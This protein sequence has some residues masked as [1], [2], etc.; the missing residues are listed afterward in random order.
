MRYSH[1]RSVTENVTHPCTQRVTHLKLHTDRSLCVQDPSGPHSVYLFIQLFILS[2]NMLC[3]KFVS[4]NNLHNKLVSF[5]ILCNQV[6]K[7]VFLS[8][9]SSYSKLIKLKGGMVELQAIVSDNL[10]L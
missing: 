1:S 8:S 7:L 6:S 4:F 5:N 10:D 3:N 2:F 9:V